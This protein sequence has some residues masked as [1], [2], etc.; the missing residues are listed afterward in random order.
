[1]STVKIINAQTIENSFVFS[2]ESDSAARSPEARHIVPL[3]LRDVVE[4]A[5]AG[6]SASQI[7]LGQKGAERATLREILDV[8]KKLGR[9]REP[10]SAA[11][12]K[13]SWLEFEIFGFNFLPEMRFVRSQP[14]ALLLVLFMVMAS[15]LGPGGLLRLY[16]YSGFLQRHN[17]YEG[18]LWWLITALT[19]IA[20]LRGL[21]LTLLSS[22]LT[23]VVPRVRLAYRGFMMDWSVDPT[24]IDADPE[25]TNRVLYWMGSAYSALA[26][27]GILSWF[28]TGTMVN[29]LKLLAL[30][31]TLLSVNPS[32]TGEISRMLDSLF[33][34]PA[35]PAAALARTR[36]LIGLVWS[37]CFF[38][39]AKNILT[40]NYDD[41]WL[42]LNLSGTGEMATVFVIAAFVVGLLIALS[43][44]FAVA[45]VRTILGPWLGRAGIALRRRKIVTVSSYNADKVLSIL[46][47]ISF[48]Q[49]VDPQVLK[50]I[51]TRGQIRQV[52]TGARVIVQ[53][54][55]GTEMFALLEGGAEVLRRDRLGL[56]ERLA[57]LRPGALFGEIALLRGGKRT[58]DV[59][60]S[61]D[62]VV[63]V[64]AKEE[65]RSLAERGSSMQELE[66]RVALSTFFADC[67]VFQGLPAET[68]QLFLQAGEFVEA[69][70]GSSLIRQGGEDQ[71]FYLLIR[72]RVLVQSKGS[73]KAEIGS[74]G[75]FGEI[76]LFERRPRTADVTA[77]E[78][79]LL[80]KL[81]R[82]AFWGVVDSN[83]GLAVA[84]EAVSESRQNR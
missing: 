16:E 10:A 66:H 32:R 72:G 50:E 63:F 14:G 79:S 27:A 75:F 35:R 6:Q 52:P 28:V 81:S 77:S 34:E 84:L 53:G 68:L 49:G 17:S 5:A 25:K 1:M 65:F 39:V 36:A 46:G 31:M 22:L 33:S 60:M 15:L 55:E 48:F 19:M 38:F 83:L 51:V 70:K 43:I 78:D 40:A 45:V 80:L 76:A 23:G 54:E 3:R 8:F 64:L 73:I 41:W 82:G 11:A 59:M 67:P 61:E 18:S 12:L 74:G 37:L 20:A 2:L 7:Y 30:L 29:D 4:R 26:A 62:S 57:D 47:G 56:E 71:N 44:D 24:R 58:A 42:R 21:L 69:A 9:V 13:K